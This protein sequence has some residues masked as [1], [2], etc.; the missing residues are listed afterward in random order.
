MS[1]GAV[2]LYRVYELPWSTGFEDDAKFKKLARGSLVAALVLGLL[3]WVLPEPQIDP[4]AAEEVPKRLVRLVLEREVPPPP[5]PPVVREEPT[6]EPEPV[7]EERVVERELEPV[8]VPEP[9]VEAPPVDRT[10]QARERASVAG[11]LPLT[12]QLQALR[13]NVTQLDRA[14]SVGAANSNTPFAERSLVTS[15]VG[16]ASGGINTAALS[17]NTGGSGLGGRET[18]V[19]ENPVEGFAEAGGAAQRSGESDK[20]SRSREEIERV[21]DANKGRIF[22]LYNRALRANPALQGKVVLR[23]TIAADGRVTFCEIVSSELNDAELERGLVQ[24]V[25]QFQF[26]ARDDIEPITTTKPIDFFPA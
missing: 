16:T 26:E 5:P 12:S 22:T 2:A 11:L 25:L 21:F 3:F 4:T 24:R 20:A 8:V 13:D 14:D 6:P 18:T 17:R 7:V 15:R 9:V 10:Q 19:V 23:L 1:N